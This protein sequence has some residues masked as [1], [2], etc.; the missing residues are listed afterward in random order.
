ML[1][2]APESVQEELLPP[3][4]AWLLETEPF[5]LDNEFIDF[6]APFEASNGAQAENGG[7][8]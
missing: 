4:L 5:I 7:V 6:V 2:T 8:S 1:F 3:K